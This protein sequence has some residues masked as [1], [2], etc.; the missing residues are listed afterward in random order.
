[1]CLSLH[2]SDF[3]SKIVFCFNFMLYSMCKYSNL[4]LMPQ[5][6]QSPFSANA[7]LNPK[8]IY[9]NQS[10]TNANTVVWVHQYNAHAWLI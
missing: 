5:I 1:M 10:L 3:T 4:K 2:A 6:D 7:A 8:V 9:S